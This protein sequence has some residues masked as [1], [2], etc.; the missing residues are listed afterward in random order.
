[1]MIMLIIMRMMMMLMMLMVIM[2]RMFIDVMEICLQ[3]RHNL[4]PNQKLD[5]FF[6]DPLPILCFFYFFFLLL[7]RPLGASRDSISAISTGNLH[8]QSPPA[9]STS[10]LHQQSPPASSIPAISNSLINLINL[11]QPRLNSKWQGGIL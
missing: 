10:N 2:M 6:L 1:M 5:N 4:R 11:H 7:L 9:I 8:R 3:E